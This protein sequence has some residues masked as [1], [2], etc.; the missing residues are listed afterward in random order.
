MFSAD[1]IGGQVPRTDIPMVMPMGGKA[2]SFG[3]SEAHS[4]H[5][6]EA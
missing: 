6:R 2:P 1:S 4:P 3:R 5:E